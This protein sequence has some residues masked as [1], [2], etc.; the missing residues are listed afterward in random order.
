MF[1]GVVAIAVASPAGAHVTIQPDSAPKGSDATLAFQVPNEMDNATTTKVQVK[2]PDD[3]PIAEALVQPIT[4]WTFKVATK[5]FPQ[6]IKTDTG[7]VNEGVDTVT[8]TAT[9][10]KGIAVGSFQQFLVSVGLPDDT[11]SLSFPTIQ[12][13]SN[14]QAVSWIETTP[15]GGTEPEHPAPAL[16]LTASGE[17]SNAT[18]TTAATGNDKGNANIAASDIAKKS[19]V[20]SAKTISIIALIVG[21]VGL[22]L[23]VGALVLSRRRA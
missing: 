2:F 5:S 19:D 3:H 22:L 12:T 18:P 16:Q 10:G 6:G 23:A 17:G 9:D 20:D 13:Y 1:G 21:I 14:G 11:D 15:P 4:G 8:W 7:T